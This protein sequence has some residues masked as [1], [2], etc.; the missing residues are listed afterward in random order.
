MTAVGMGRP[1]RVAAIMA[2]PVNPAMRVAQASVSSCLRG[3][4]A[5]VAWADRTRL[6]IVATMNT[7]SSI[8]LKP[9]ARERLERVRDA[10]ARVELGHRSPV[11]AAAV[12]ADAGLV[13]QA[14]IIEVAI[15][16]LAHRRGTEAAVKG[17][18]CV[19]SRE[20]DMKLPTLLNSLVAQFDDAFC[21]GLEEG[22]CI[23]VNVQGVGHIREPAFLM[24]GG[25]A[26]Q[27]PQRI[28][29]RLQRA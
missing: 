3:R 16:F 17:T 7:S 18:R 23:V 8:M 27:I 1:A 25:E 24:D 22:G 10:L 19:S 29:M 28:T 2:G 5:G 13:F 9:D 15:Q 20:R 14:V 26:S 21:R 4:T 6:I 12:A 11:A